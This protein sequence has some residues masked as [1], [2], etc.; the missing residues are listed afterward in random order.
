MRKA[1]QL[2][3]GANGKKI[4]I[5]NRVLATIQQKCADNKK[6]LA[7]LID[8]EKCNHLNL[9]NLIPLLNNALP[10]FIFVGGSQHRSPFDEFILQLR[11]TVSVPVVL[12]PG[13]ATQFSKHAHALLFLSLLSG[14]NAKY[15]IG[16]HVK[17][18]L[19]IHKSELEVIPTAY[20]LIDGGVCSAVELV[21]QTKPIPRTN[22]ELI[23]ATSLAG[24]ML[25]MQL[26][27]LEAGSGALVPVMSETIMHVKSHLSIPLIVGGGIKTSE[28]LTNA[29]TGGADLV[30]VGNV[31]EKNPEFLQELVGVRNKMNM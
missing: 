27:Y 28:Q 9:I 23:I 10:D 18:A 30:V 1:L 29:F 26:V 8:P 6:L 4:G 16:Q 24:Q 25:G 15:L 7:V 31:L 2:E 21:S 14:R 3:Q 13:D 11:R 19:K 5:M 12:F 22:N 20:V 17:S